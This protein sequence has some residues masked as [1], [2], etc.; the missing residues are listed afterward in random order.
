V[1]TRSKY[2]YIVLLSALVVAVET[3]AVEGAIK[4][5][6]LSSF[7]V[8][9]V[10]P[11]VGGAILMGLNPKGTSRFASSLTPKGWLKM[12]VLCGFVA[13]GV[14]LWFDAVGRIGASKEAILGGGSSEVLFIVLLSAVFLSERLKKW[15][16]V[17]SVLVMAGVFIVLA[18]LDTLSLSIGLGELEAIL[19]SLLL[20]I[21]VVMTTALLKT[22]DLGPFSCIELLLTGAF[23]LI[24]G[25]ATGLIEWEGFVG[26]IILGL[27]GVLPALGMVM[28]NAGLPRIGA[29]LTSVLFALTGI[30]T[31]AVQ[32]VV[33]L[34]FPD[35]DIE[36][37]SSVPL[38]LLGGAV[39]F[40]GVYLLNSNSAGKSSDT[41]RGA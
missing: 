24:I 23:L 5:A 19:S 32:L 41:G 8:S 15:E 6:D 14:F 10:P 33:L 37:P 9:A 39:A 3:V 38:A 26:M 36:L 11:L 7:I 25:V 2:I 27:I 31:V 1:D 28:Y 12:C 40:A 35:A 4:I 22:K 13:G 34:L 20:G 21:S 29:S 17:G 30:M 16:A 18:D